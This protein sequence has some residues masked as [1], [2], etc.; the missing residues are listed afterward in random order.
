MLYGQVKKLGWND[1]SDF[2]AKATW[3]VA[4]AAVTLLFPIAI[5]N[6]Y[7]GEVY[8]GLGSLGIVC[9]L[10]AN[11]IAVSKGLDHQKMTLYGLV[12]AGMLFMIG[13]F[14][15]DGLIGAL[16]CYPSIIACYCM[17]SERRAWIA[18]TIIL[19]VC[20]PM[21]WLFIPAQYL[22]RIVATLLSISLFSGILVRVID[23]QNRRLQEQLIRD[24]LTGL[25]NRISLR[26]E[27]QDAIDSYDGSGQCASLL[28]I[29]VDHFKLINDTLGH[30]SG[31]TA[32]IALANLFKDNLRAE[33]ACFRIGGEEFLVLL[34]GMNEKD[35]F[36]VA[37]RL[38]RLVEISEI[39]P[40]ES[41]TISI[42][43]S[44]YSSGETWTH[45]VK[46]ADDSLYDAKRSGRNRVA[47]ANAAQKASV[48]M[49]S[50][51]NALRSLDKVENN[52]SRN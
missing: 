38:R 25:L 51:S 22:Y 1:N 11:V 10:A 47:I 39:I 40:Q 16:W 14:S 23:E 46:R 17:L 45:W 52:S 33:D 4:L 42:G 24:P 37:E 7:R 29:D 21:A 20:L 8:V 44:T 5:L 49:F 32:L 13:V 27:L 18:N 31:D 34:R 15:K 48:S 36:S 6:L 30:E 19:G 2:R 35:A 43:T 50:R 9:M 41:L 12:P 3:G 26:A 28:A